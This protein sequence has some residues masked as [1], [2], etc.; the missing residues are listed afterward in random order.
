MDLSILLTPISGDLAHTRAC[1]ESLERTLPPRLDWELLLFDN[2]SSPAPDF[3]HER[4]R[5]LPSAPA[6]NLPFGPNLPALRNAAVAAARAPLL[7]FL[8]P[9]AVLLPGWLPPMLDLLHRAPLAGCI[10]NIH[11]EPYSGLI[12]HA[13]LRFDAD[14]LPFPVAAGTA[15]LPRETRDRHPAVSLTC[16]LVTRALFDQLGG[17]DARFHGALGDVDFCLRAAALGYRHS[18]ANR[19]VIYHYADAALIPSES[20]ADLAFYRTFWGARAR[21][22]HARRAILF[23]NP[24]AGYTRE[25][26]EMARE[27]C[28]LHRQQLLDIRRDGHSY[29]RKHLH[30]PWRYNY[31]RLCRAL[32]KSFPPLPPPLPSTPGE[33]FHDTADTTRPDDGWLFDPPPQ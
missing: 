18:V 10:G 22:A 2:Q 7:C 8:S 16:A 31:A 13:G 30:R 3:R 1:L 17:F 12:D 20:D 33:P 27:S 6:P 14:G 24:A 25:G 19:S 21:A 15:L 23:Q 4:F 29:L 9:N 5:F 26:W 32:G 11:R 28:R